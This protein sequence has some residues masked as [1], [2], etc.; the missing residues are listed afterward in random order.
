[1]RAFI[2]VLVFVLAGCA[3]PGP[4]T[5]RPGSPSQ[6]S[7]SPKPEPVDV[8]RR[9][10]VLAEE[11]FGEILEDLAQAREQVVTAKKAVP[12]SGRDAIDAVLDLV[13]AA[14][15]RVADLNNEL[16]TDETWKSFKAKQQATKK[17]WV[18]DLNDSLFEVAEARRAVESLGDFAPQERKGPYSL[19]TVALGDATTGLEVAIEALGGTVEP[20]D[21]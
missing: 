11:Q 13:D 9:A 19:A 8:D 12:S 14:A 4:D 2:A 17:R 10:F 21:P 6:G 1:M 7:E 20:V 3:S 18:D 5:V 16:P 15:G